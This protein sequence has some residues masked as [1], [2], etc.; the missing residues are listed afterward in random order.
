MTI[1]ELFKETDVV[2]E[3]AIAGIPVTGLQYDSRKVTHGDLFIA[4]R[5]Y[6]T[7]GHRFLQNACDNGAVAL[8]V[9]EKNAS[10][11]VPQIVVDDSRYMMSLLAK[12]YY[13]EQLGRIKLIGITGTN[14]KTTVSY[15]VRSI[16][17]ASGIS[18]GL[19]GTIAYWIGREQID[20][21]NTTPEAIDLY[22]MLAKMQEAG[23]QMAVL[24]VSSHALALRRVHGLSF[25]VGLFT[26]LSRDHL[27]FHSSMD[28]YFAEKTK[29]F[30]QL[31][32][33]GVAVVNFDD[34]YGRRIIE[35]MT[36][37]VLSYG[38]E[39]GAD[40]VARDWSTSARGTRLNVYYKDEDF[41]IV[42][43]LI[44]AFNVYNV[45]SAVAVA[46]AYNIPREA[47]A[48]GVAHLKNVPG[49][50]ENYVLKNGATAVIDYAHTPDAL[51]KALDVCRGLTNRQLH[52][53]FGCGGD[54]DKGKRPLMAEVAARLA[55]RVIITDDN[56]RTEDPLRIIRDIQ[57]GLP[58]QKD[59]VE[60]IH[61]RAG[62][63]RHALQNAEKGDV[64]LIAG[65]GHEK[66]Q[67][68]GTEKRPFDEVEIVKEF[69]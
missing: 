3:T 57:A 68:I 41:E 52:V 37:P 6:V 61:N 1:G 14:G 46:L 13:R 38:L 47:I 56:P 12:N 18:C 20:A 7:D 34:A 60:I 22:A 32:A 67:I 28:S 26:N 9:E 24:E 17:E 10:L 5:G 39:D 31:D 49:R 54:R 40:V 29:L 36:T 33:D 53:V 51:E 59:H 45:L 27:D 55:D 25:R 50:L 11:D 64:V 4:I 58:A 30:A 35:N 8:V 15:L 44:G 16:V 62:A 2:P 65:K 63:I 19:A 48:Y 23:N 21:W 42:S 66:Y 43:P 69:E